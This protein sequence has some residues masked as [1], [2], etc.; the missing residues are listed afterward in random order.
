MARDL[1]YLLIDEWIWLFILVPLFFVLGIYLTYKTGLVQCRFIKETWN[2]LFEKTT[3]SVGITPL[4]AF[5]LSMAGRV[6]AGN[7]IGVAFAISVA[8]P[9]AVFWMW[10]VAFFSMALAFIEN[11]LVQVYKVKIDDIYQG[12]PA[13]YISKGL[14]S[15]KLGMLFALILIFVFGLLFNIIQSKTIIDMVSITYEIQSHYWVLGILLLL[16]AISIFGGLRRI[17]HVTEIIVPLVLLLY[18][19]VILYVTLMNLSSI[20]AVLKLILINAFGGKEM[21]IGALAAAMVQGVKRG[22]L[23]NG[24]GMGS[25]TLAGS[26]ANT[27]HPAKQGLLQSLGIFV[28]TFFVS[29]ITAF[30]ILQSGLYGHGIP[31]GILLA[32]A[33][34]STHLG[35]F[36]PYYASI[37]LLL[38]SFAAIVGNYYYGETNIT[39]L[40][41]R[42]SILLLYRFAVLGML[43]LGAFVNIELLWDVVTLLV[44][45]MTVINLVVI[46]LLSGT[47]FKVWDNYLQQKHVGKVPYFYAEDIPELTGAECWNKPEELKEKTREDAYFKAMP[48]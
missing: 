31:N 12:G 33:A 45:S 2:S 44:G 17:S 40:S 24:T 25:A 27:R 16:T 19:S 37:V 42:K 4:Q 20:P 15:P 18:L 28:D 11:I 1:F 47:A 8:G 46:F 48:R 41:R 35:G 21:A 13:Y 34:I 9:G 5:S 30:V 26:T 23:F 14:N 10:V 22:L 7:V 38:T 39:F 32:Q 29:G 43:V 36:A 3:D 6:G